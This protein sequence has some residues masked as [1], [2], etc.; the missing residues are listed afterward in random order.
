MIFEPQMPIAAT[1]AIRHA[2]TT[3]VGATAVAPERG[4]KR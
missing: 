1:L 3:T 2:A 4:Y